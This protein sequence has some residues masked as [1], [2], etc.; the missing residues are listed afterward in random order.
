MDIVYILGTGSLAQDEEIRYSL[1][2]IEKHMQDLDNVY[3]VG[4]RPDFLI[5]IKHI[6]CKDPHGEK[7][8]N[9]HHKIMTACN[10]GELS[11]EFLLMNDDF[12]AN[13]DFIGAELPFYAVKNG[14]GGNCGKEDYA[15]HAPVR[16]NKKFFKSMPFPILEKGTYSPR[17]F[18]CNFFQAPPKFVKDT[19]I[20]TGEGVPSYDEQVKGAEW[21]S[22]G[23]ST[24][25]VLDF[26]VWL[27]EKYPQPSNFED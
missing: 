1:R 9:A 18:F 23:S 14:S 24:M 2:S 12:F 19:I 8:K 15:V 10:L 3:V 16:Y 13:A 26:S 11:E 4:E 25:T 20:T 22:I 6:S 5:N 27:Q 21:F 7:W 17:T